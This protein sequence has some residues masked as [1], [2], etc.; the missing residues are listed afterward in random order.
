MQNNNDIFTKFGFD[1]VVSITQ[2]TINDQIAQLAEVSVIKT[3]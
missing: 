2:R 1:I 3:K